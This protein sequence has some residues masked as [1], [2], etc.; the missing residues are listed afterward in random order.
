MPSGTDAVRLFRHSLHT[1]WSGP[2]GCPCVGWTLIH[3]C[4]PI[5][6]RSGL[7]MPLSLP[8]V[9]VG[10]QEDVAD[11]LACRSN[12]YVQY[13]D[14]PAALLRSEPLSFQHPRRFR[15]GLSS[16]VR[17]VR[18]RCIPIQHRTLPLASSLR[19][20]AAAEQSDVA[21]SEGRAAARTRVFT[22]WGLGV[23]GAHL[24]AAQAPG[25]LPLPVGGA[26]RACSSPLTRSGCIGST[27][28]ARQARRPRNPAQPLGQVHDQ[29]QPT[30][31]EVT[32]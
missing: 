6:Q 9:A 24:R 3:T 18:Q 4:R 16:S 12:S 10:L 15:F 23:G 26:G 14:S 13:T 7:L 25:A 2:G 29:A 30:G 22:R 27:S 20:A 11:H 28:A 32:R 21:D 31:Y 8:P 19:S 1:H 5:R 17:S